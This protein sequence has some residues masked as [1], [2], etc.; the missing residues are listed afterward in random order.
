[1]AVLSELS[2][3]NPGDPN[4]G[5]SPARRGPLISLAE[6]DYVYIRNEGDGREQ[7][8]NE[9][10]DPREVDNH[11][12]SATM[13]PILRRFRDHLAQLKSRS[14]SGTNLGSQP[15]LIP[16]NKDQTVVADGV[17]PVGSM[18]DHRQIGG[19]N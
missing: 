18:A 17:R 14:L 19:A 7:L 8:F 12:R 16:K 15:G 13:L 10:D 6:G 5:R 11:A 3:P 4:Q 2:S 9:R 1:M